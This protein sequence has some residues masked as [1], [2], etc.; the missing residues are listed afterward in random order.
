MA[1]KIAA[2]PYAEIHSADILLKTANLR[3]TTTKENC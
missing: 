3:R 2:K 1:I